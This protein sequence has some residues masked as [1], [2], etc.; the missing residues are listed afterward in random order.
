MTAAEILGLYADDYDEARN[1]FVHAAETR[2]LPVHSY[3]LDLRGPKGEALAVDAV[4][5]G[6]PDASKL[7]IVISGVH[8]VEGYPG[9]AIQ[10]GAL[11]LGTP[12][13]CG[14]DHDTAVLHVHAI[15]PY[16][17]AYTRR[18]TQENVDLNR[19]FVDFADAL[20]RNPGYDAIHELL[21]PREWPPAAAVEAR[22]DDFRQRE[23]QKTFQRALSLGQY[24]HP[25]GI[26]FGGVAP[27]WSNTTFRAILRRYAQAC[28]HIGSI[29]IHT[30]LGPYGLG[31]RIFACLEEGAAL[32]R[33]TSW[34][35][36]LTS[37][38]TGSSTS[39]PLTGPIQQALYDECRQAS[40]TNICLEYGTVPH[41]EMVQALRAEHWL[42]R[43]GT[44][45]QAIS[46]SVK[47]ALR[48]AFFPDR[49]DWKLD[50]WRQG[51]AAFRQALTGLKVVG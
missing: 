21:L 26:H 11:G 20:P 28:R 29:D 17:F 9:S 4:L 39:V 3:E 10:T 18:A 46:S 2:G 5:D 7:L 14:A 40:K 36:E 15:N 44:R 27:T 16:G 47:R 31:E 38:T 45:D 48:D 35:G 23:G 50:I 24:T 51:E 12:R 19:N 33:A 22:L 34:W 32:D 49:D 30:G 25:D 37:V 8:G 43:N 6:P 1:K 41:R 13:S 42:H